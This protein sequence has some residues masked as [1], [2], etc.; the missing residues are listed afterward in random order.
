MIH[1]RRIAAS[2]MTVALAAASLLVAAPAQASPG[3][4]YITSYD[5]PL[6][7]GGGHYLVPE[8]NLSY[9]MNDFC[10]TSWQRQINRRYG[11]VLTVD[12]IYG[13]RTRDWTTRIQGSQQYAWCA[14]GVDGIAGPRT[15]SCFEH[16]NG[17]SGWE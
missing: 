12:G 3:T 13:P 1:A 2:C 8:Y 15:I 5:N 17:Y 9:G 16:V 6:I 11:Q 10:V 14:G 7:P 4:C